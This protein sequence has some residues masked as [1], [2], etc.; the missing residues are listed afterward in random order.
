MARR[1]LAIAGTLALLMAMAWGA[2]DS[3]R[4]FATLPR[5]A[6]VSTPGLGAL[7][8][9]YSAALESG[10][11]VCVQPVTL[12]PESQ[13]ARFRIVGPGKPPISPLQITATGP[14]YRSA[15]IFRQYEL[16]GDQTPW[17]PITPPRAEVVGRVCA[18]NLGRQRVEVIGNAEQRSQGPAEVLVNGE[19]QSGKE[20]ELTLLRA[21]PQSMLDRPGDLIANARTLAADYAP[22]W[23]LWGVLLLVAFGIPAA[24]TVGFFRVLSREP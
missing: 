4:P 5:E 14:G 13:I 24:V 18:K 22:K 15:T 9:R 7:E 3:L 23:L 19:V 2:L 6:V 11:E 21:T 17:I 10:D 1:R 12:T 16:A 20:L 8:S